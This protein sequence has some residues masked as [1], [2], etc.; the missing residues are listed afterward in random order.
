MFTVVSP[1]RKNAKN[2]ARAIGPPPANTA[3]ECRA[4][5]QN[6]HC[7]CRGR[8]SI[9][10]LRR[11]IYTDRILEY[12]LTSV[13]AGSHTHH[14][15]RLQQGESRGRS[16]EPLVPRLSRLLD[17]LQGLIPCD[18]AEA[19]AAGENNTRDNLLHA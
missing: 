6:L 17:P 12:I 14:L 2:A 18:I 10:I 16:G 11:Y 4:W 8:L 19:A 7:I 5:R 13:R 1:A 9:Y 3:V 15:I